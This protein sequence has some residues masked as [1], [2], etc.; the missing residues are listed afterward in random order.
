MNRALM[1]AVLSVVS[2]CTC[3]RGLEEDIYYP[4][5]NYVRDF[6]DTIACRE[7]V[8]STD[9]LHQQMLGKIQLAAEEAARDG[10]DLATTYDYSKLYYARRHREIKSL[11]FLAFLDSLDTAE[12]FELHTYRHAIVEACSLSVLEFSAISEF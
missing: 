7:K 8:Y 11:V 9:E 10:D 1:L 12:E 3:P 6:D 2:G 4:T 5:L